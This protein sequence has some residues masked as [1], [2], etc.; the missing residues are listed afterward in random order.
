MILFEID[1]TTVVSN[2]KLV[3]VVECLWLYVTICQILFQLCEYV[4]ITLNI[5]FINYI[6]R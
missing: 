1:V 4:S 5:L 3:T 6:F 2:N